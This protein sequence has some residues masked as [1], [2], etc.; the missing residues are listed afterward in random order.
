MTRPTYSALL[1]LVCLLMTVAT[2][3]PATAGPAQTAVGEP[4]PDL[5]FPTVDG[6]QTVR[7][8]DHRGKRVLLI[9][10]ASW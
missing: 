6:E 4:F 5:V 3:T 2:P 1:L 9:E 10:F 7:L 8:S